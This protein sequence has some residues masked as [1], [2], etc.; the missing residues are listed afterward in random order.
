MHS[1]GA[2]RIVE[3]DAFLDVLAEGGGA[4]DFLGRSAQKVVL[5]RR[6]AATKV[7][8]RLPDPANRST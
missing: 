6:S 7:A 2:A 5:V 3:P 8:Q 4:P 1:C